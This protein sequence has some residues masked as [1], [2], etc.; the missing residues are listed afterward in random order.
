[1]PT[2]TTIQMLAG[3]LTVPVNGAFPTRSC[4]VYDEN[5]FLL[6]GQSITWSVPGAGASGTF[7]ATGTAAPV[8]TVT[9]NNAQG[10]IGYSGDMHANAI[11]GAWVGTVIATGFP[12]AAGSF[13]ITNQLPPVVT[14]LD[15]FIGTPQTVP[16]NAAYSEVYV[17]VV[18]QYGGSLSGVPVTFSVPA[19][20]G[21]FPGG[22]TTVVVNSNAG[23]NAVSPVLTASAVL[24]TFSWTITSGSITANPTA[25]FT[26]VSATA[27]TSISAYSGN[28]QITPINTPFPLPLVA[29][30]ANALNN[31]VAGVPIV[32]TAPASGPSCAWPA[33][34]IITLTVVT[35]ANGLAQSPIMTANGTAGAYAVSAASGAIV[36]YFGLT[37]GAAVASPENPL[38]LCE[39]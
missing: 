5:G 10:G 14:T 26:T 7:D 39:A 31:P 23:G 15:V 33:P 11:G 9:R 37:N 20:V 12:A 4:R 27:L 28:N 13:S 17:A 34:F 18:D 38:Q 35:D 6:Y 30:A 25:I 2:P 22:L 29:R 24:G 16:Q 32:F 8:V 3:P 36:G 21:T 1:M 19:G